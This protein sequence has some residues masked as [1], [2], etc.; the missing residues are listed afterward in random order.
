MT[1]RWRRVVTLHFGGGRYGEHALD[2]AACGE[3]QRF[4]TLVTDTAKRFG[5]TRSQVVHDCRKTSR[6][7]TSYGFVQ[8]KMAVPQ[9]HL[10]C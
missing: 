1:D 10:R 5:D 2:A 7:E 9:S 3:L 8:L 6:A 4:Q